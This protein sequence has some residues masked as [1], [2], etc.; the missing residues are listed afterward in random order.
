MISTNKLPNLQV[1]TH[2]LSVKLQNSHVGNL[3][4]MLATCT[5]ID[6]KQ[7]AYIIGNSQPRKCI[8]AYI[9]GT[10]PLDACYCYAEVHVRETRA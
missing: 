6:S 7:Q 9:I 3:L 10:R 2:I 8:V 4:R 5:Y 1:C